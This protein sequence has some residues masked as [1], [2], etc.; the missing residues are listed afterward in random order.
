MIF[1]NTSNEL[2]EY[3]SGQTA[4]WWGTQA[5]I[6]VGGIGTCAVVAIWTWLFPELRR[7]DRFERSSEAPSEP[8]G[9]SAGKAT[10]TPAAGGARGQGR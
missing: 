7:A 6:V 10:S 5:A 2:G 1:I 9:L 8:E 4:H 3:R